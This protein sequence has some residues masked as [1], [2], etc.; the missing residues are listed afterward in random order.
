[1]EGLVGWRMARHCRRMRV[2]CGAAARC[3]RCQR[4][5]ARLGR[6]GLC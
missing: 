5:S 3:G 4:E 1:M 2:E 6:R